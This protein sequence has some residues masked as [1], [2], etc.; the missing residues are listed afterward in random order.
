MLVETWQFRLGR[1]VNLLVFQ[2]VDYLKVFRAVRLISAYVVSVLKFLEPSVDKHGSVII[3]WVKKAREHS[4]GR[5]SPPLV[6][7]NSPQ[8]DEQE[9]RIAR[10][11]ADAFGLREFRL[12]GSDA[13]QRVSLG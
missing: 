12:Y 9:A 3:V 4:R 5:A 2:P 1:L 11:P 13:R 10:K 6:V 8:H 7:G